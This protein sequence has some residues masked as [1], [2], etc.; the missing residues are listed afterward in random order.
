MRAGT[1]RARITPD[2]AGADNF[3]RIRTAAPLKDPITRSRTTH[4]A[5]Q[6]PPFSILAITCKTSNDENRLII[7]LES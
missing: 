1:G 6:S 2:S 7:H 5:Q 4:G 3:D